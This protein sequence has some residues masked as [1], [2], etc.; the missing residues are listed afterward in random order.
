MSAG[1]KILEL[2]VRKIIFYTRGTKISITLVTLTYEYL[3]YTINWFQHF[4]VFNLCRWINKMEYI[5]ENSHT[6]VLESSWYYLTKSIIDFRT[7][8]CLICSEQFECTYIYNFFSIH[9]L[10]EVKDFFTSIYLIILLKNHKYYYFIDYTEKTSILA[11]FYTFVESFILIILLFVESWKKLLPLA[12]SAY[13]V[14]EIRRNKR[15][16]QKLCC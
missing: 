2:R 8:V 5:S 4:L 10:K 7:F 15:T 11:L 14:D 12:E 1:R 9:W 3:T 16:R 13:W 6:I